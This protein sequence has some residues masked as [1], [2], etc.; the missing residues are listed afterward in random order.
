MDAIVFWG[1]FFLTIIVKKICNTY[2][3]THSKNNNEEDD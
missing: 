3:E 1:M 2:I